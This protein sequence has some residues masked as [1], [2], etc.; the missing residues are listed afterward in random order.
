MQIGKV[1]EQIGPTV[2]TIRF[3]EKQQLLKQASPFCFRKG[4]LR[5]TTLSDRFVCGCWLGF[6]HRPELLRSP[7]YKEPV[8]EVILSSHEAVRTTVGDSARWIEQ[9]NSQAATPDADAI[10]TEVRP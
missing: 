9:V 3:Y 2:D 8:A 5:N 4:P 6:L 10:Q 7:L 1:A